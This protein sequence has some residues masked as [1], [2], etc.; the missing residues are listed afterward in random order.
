M[1]KIQLQ[2]LK[3]MYKKPHIVIKSDFVYIIGELFSLV[4]CNCKHRFNCNY[5]F[6]NFSAY[7]LGIISLF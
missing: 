7:N 4:I 2:K 6:I 1:N 5:L 3:I